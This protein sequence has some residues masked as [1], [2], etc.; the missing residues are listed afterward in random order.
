MSERRRNIAVGITVIVALALLGSLI[1]IFAGLPS[2]FTGGYEVR[3]LLDASYDLA[4]GDP[5]YMSGIRVGT[6]TEVGFADPAQPG[7]GVMVIAKIDDEIRLPGNLKP[8]VYTRGFTGKGYLQLNTEGPYPVDAEG[9]LVQFIA[10]GSKTPIQGEGRGSGLIPDDFR[11]AIKNV[12]DLAQ[13]LN[14]LV[15]PPTTASAPGTGPATASA[16]A[17]VS[18]TGTITRL[19]RALDS[20]TEVTG[21]PQNQ[22]NIR[23]MLAN[24]STASAQAAEAMTSL[25]AFAEQART[26]TASTSGHIDQLMGQLIT[27]AQGLSTMLATINKAAIKLD[28]GQGTAGKLLNDPQLYNNLTE[29]T[30][31]LNRLVAQMQLLIE[32]WQKEGIELKMR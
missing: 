11:Q 9:R 17:E 16:P 23:T 25:K 26:T 21:D 12:A 4:S 8:V 29:A 10:K 3:I 6:I 13:N 2:M 24:L 7:G 19:N 32:S 22:E 31:Q 30:G 18:L 14:R 20:I 27:D 28:Q 5:V 15:S 1:L